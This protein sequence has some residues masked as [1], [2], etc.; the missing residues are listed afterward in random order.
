MEAVS[1]DPDT[2]ED[3]KDI[4]DTLHMRVETVAIIFFI[5]FIVVCMAISLGC[6]YMHHRYAE[7]QKRATLPALESGKKSK[8]RSP[9]MSMA[10]HWRNASTTSSTQGLLPTQPKRAMLSSRSTFGIMGPTNSSI[11]LVDQSAGPIS[12]KDAVLCRASKT[13]SLTLLDFYA[14]LDESPQIHQ[15]IPASRSQTL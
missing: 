6:W 2:I 9:Q 13:Y 12:P 4:A 3:F 10:T 11:T 8:T 7:A 5:V 1:D 15:G 14:S